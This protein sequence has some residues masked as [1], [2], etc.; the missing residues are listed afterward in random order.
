MIKLSQKEA[1]KMINKLY[2]IYLISKRYK[3]NFSKIKWE[4]LIELSLKEACDA[5]KTCDLYVQKHVP[6][7]D[8]GVLSSRT[9][10]ITHD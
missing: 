1:Y 9:I 5:Q 3:E 6:L 2:V 4:Y 10:E 8:I 7:S